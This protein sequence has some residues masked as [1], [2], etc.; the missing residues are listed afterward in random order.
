MQKG[1]VE[2]RIMSYDVQSDIIISTSNS[3]ETYF[4]KTLYSY[5]L[6][7]YGFLLVL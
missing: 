3:N 5:Q 6:S 4:Y 7:K 2:W 1:V